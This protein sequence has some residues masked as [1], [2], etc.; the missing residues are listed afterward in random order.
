MV[1]CRVQSASSSGSGL[2]LEPDGTILTSAQIVS[3]AA[4]TRR[5]INGKMQLPRVLI[6]LQDGRVFRGRVISSDR[7]AAAWEACGS[8]KPAS[9]TRPCTLP[10]WS[11]FASMSLVRQHEVLGL[12]W[13]VCSCCVTLLWAWAKEDWVCRATDLAIV[14]VDSRDPLPCAQLGTSAGL[15]VGEWVLALG[16]PL[17]LHNS[18]TAGIVSCVD[19]KVTLPASALAPSL[20]YPSSPSQESST[21]WH[22]GFGLAYAACEV[23]LQLS[24]RQLSLAWLGQT[25]STSRQM[26]PPIAATLAGLW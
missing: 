16:S 6:T 1:A 4:E 14:K 3:A 21:T 22:H 9:L 17:H 12:H 25:L 19:R 18:V 8:R 15:R 11:P 20:L 10:P 2:I 7:Q 23:M 5:G 24:C 13:A 26:R